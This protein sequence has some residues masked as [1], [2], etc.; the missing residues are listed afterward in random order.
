MVGKI[1]TIASLIGYYFLQMLCKYI[2][3]SFDKCSKVK[4]KINLLV[5]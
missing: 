4:R 2:M 3:N 1:Y 5:K